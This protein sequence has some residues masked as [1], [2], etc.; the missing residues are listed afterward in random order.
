MLARNAEQLTKK[1]ASKWIETLLNLPD[2]GGT[3]ADEKQDWPDVPAGRYALMGEQNP[4]PNHPNPNDDD[5]ITFYKV[6]RPTEGRWTGYTF[7]SAGKGGPHGEPEWIAIRKAD[8]K[9]ALLEEI[10]RDPGSAA[11]MYGMELGH[12]GVCG[13]T[14]TDE[15]SRQYGIGPV[16][17]ERTG[18]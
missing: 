8:R 16:C 17:R 6:D 13:R 7:L 2:K 4:G 11:Q 5:T 9:R 3:A 10:A 12:C 18:W 14:L 15:T 1:Q